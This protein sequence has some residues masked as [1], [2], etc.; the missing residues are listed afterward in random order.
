MKFVAVRAVQLVVVLV[1]AT[2][3]VYSLTFL[4][5]GDEA[6]VDS[7]LQIEAGSDTRRSEVEDGLNIDDPLPVRYVKWAGDALTGDFGKSYVRGRPVWDLMKEPLVRT[8][9]LVAYAQVLALVL[10][11]PAGIVAAWRANTW[12][13]RGVSTTAIALLAVPNYVLAIV[14]VF[15]FASTLDIFPGIVD[16]DLSPLDLNSYILPAL[17]LALPQVAVYMR[18]LR[19]D[20]IATLQEDYI[21]MAKA[22]GLSTRSILFRHALRPSSLSLVTTV[23]LSTGALIGGTVIIEQIFAMPGMGTL[24]VR[25][26]FQDDIFVIQAVVAVIAFAF[27]V[28]NF[29]VDVL[30]A[31]LDPRIR[32]A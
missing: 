3:F 12:I 17:S 2:F 9:A 18:L 19:T 7:I 8:L 11:V 16:S 27:V 29:I 13:D 25:S 31:A 5:D 21:G 28:I 30:Y 4:A 20:M 22:K 32:S 1:A 14:L 15:L 6:V 10:A 24:V 23:G 26:I